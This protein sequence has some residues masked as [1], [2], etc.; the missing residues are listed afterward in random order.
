[1]QVM[2]IIWGGPLYWEVALGSWKVCKK[3]NKHARAPCTQPTMG[4]MGTS[5]SRCG[6]TVL[7][8]DASGRSRTGTVHTITAPD[9]ATAHPCSPC[10][11]LIE[12]K[13]DS[14]PPGGPPH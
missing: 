7:S 6:T 9:Q 3:K 8:P 11:P 2:S 4:R 5:P 13:H 14:S 12:H 10:C 1:M